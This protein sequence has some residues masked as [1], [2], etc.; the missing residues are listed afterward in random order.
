MKRNRPDIIGGAMRNRNIVIIITLLFM[1]TGVVALIKMP[2]NE[3]PV[4]TIRQGV[5]IGVF[6]GATSSEVEAQLTRV[7]ENYIFSYKEINKAKTY[8][9]S[10]EGMMYIFVQL[11]DNV[12]NS[13]QFWSKI[14]H[15]LSE[16]KMTLPA[17]VIAL[18][19]NSDFGDTSALLITLSSDNRSYKELEE[20]LKKLESECRKIPATSKIRHFGLQK[21]KIFVDIRPEMLNEYNIKAISLLGSYRLDGMVNYAGT[22]KDSSNNLA[23]H[24]P[25]NYESE[26]DL[27]DQIV[28]S[29]PSGN[30]VRLKNIASIERRYGEPDNYI[31]Q[32]GKK[33]ILLSLEM[34]TGNNIVEYGKQVD[35]ALANFEKTCPKDIQITK[36]SELPKYVDDSIG[37]FL[38]EFLVAIVSVMLVTMLLLPFRIASVAGITV[39][40]SVLVTLSFLYF[41]GVELHMVSLSSL[42]LVLGMIVDNAIVVI[43]N[44]VE[45]IDQGGSSW[46]AAIRSAKELFIP[47]VTATLAIMAAY[48]PLG[49]IL[50][51]SVGEF[52]KTIPIVVSTALIVSILVACFLVPYLN[53]TFIK[54]GLRRRASDRPTFLDK[55]Q[56]R[57][58]KALEGAFRHPKMILGSTAILLGISV[59]IFL[60]LDQQLFPEVERN[61]FVVEINLPAGSSLK[62]TGVVVDSISRLLLK[63]KR[64][65]HVTSFTGTSSPR[66]HTVYAPNMPAPHYG[67]LLVNTISDKA[68]RQVVKEYN[69][70]YCNIF[71]NAHVS[72]RILALSTTKIPIEIRISSDSI[73]D[74]RKVESE[75]N[76][77][78]KQ[79]SHIYWV[80]NDWDQMQQN[81]RVHLDHDKANRLGY[82]KTFVS[83]GLM[84]GLEGLPLTTI[85]EDDYPVEVRLSQKNEGLKGIRKLEDQSITSPLSMKST[86]LRSFATFSPE[87]TEGTIA[88]RNGIRTM[89]IQVDNDPSVTATRIFKQIK[90][91]IEKLSLP[92]GTSISYG[93]EY[94][95]QLEV[96]D[97]MIVALMLSI[98]IIFFILLF[99]FKKIK[100]T[101]LII[102]TMILAFPG[103]AIGLKLMGYNFSVTAFIGISSLCGMVVRNGII[104]VDYIIK[105]RKNKNIT[106]YEAALAAGK[107]RMRPIFLTSS[108]AAVGVI[109]MIISGSLLWGPLGTVICFGLILAMVLTLFVL[110]ILY[111]VLFK[112]TDKMK[113]K[114]NIYSTGRLKTAGLIIIL[115]AGPVWYSSGQ[116]SYSLDSCKQISLEN[117][118]QLGNSM[119]ELDISKQV[120]QAA[121]T[122]YFPNVSASGMTIS[123]NEPLISL[124]IK[125]GNLPV[126]NGDPTTI[127]HA[128]QFAYSPGMSISLLDRLSTGMLNATQPLF[129]GGRIYFGN[130]LAKVGVSASTDKLILTRNEVL[131]KTEEQYWT[132]QTLTDKLKTIDMYNQLL[133][134]LERDVKN[135]YHSGLINHNDLLRVSLKKSELEMNRIRLQNGIKLAK[136]AFCQQMGILYDSNMVLSDTVPADQDP[137][138]YLIMS[139]KV[140][141]N[142]AEY[143]LVQENVRAGQ[144][145]YKMKRGE[146]LPELAVGT[147]AFSYNM[148]D[149]WNNKMMLY[150]TLTIPLSGWWEASHTLKEESLKVKMAHNNAENNEKLLILQVEKAWSDLVEAYEQIR[151]ADNSVRLA[152]ENLKIADDNYHSGLIGVSGLLE[153]QTILQDSLNSMTD[154]RYNY[155]IRLA[156]Y[157]VVTERYK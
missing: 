48:I 88:H 18:I 57:F 62:S 22:L 95:G 71:P 127:P 12:K 150:G 99:Q 60:N 111:W 123:F 76:G 6:P 85:W 125:G 34:Q 72:Y 155:R 50:P 23:V 89:S 7:V 134:T 119:I 103:G 122:K 24:L 21:E 49:F 156:R 112:N 105:L 92:E 101:L 26:K 154:A 65:T 115:L 66:F 14:K 152:R 59:V 149:S 93:G 128:T 45:K 153:A 151:L 81:I 94:E 139:E 19:A 11:N 35:K 121:F 31:R 16:L 73:K 44:H 68:T 138:F 9:Y 117:N 15:G 4:F 124:N 13:D 55:L 140:I 3:F 102:F 97:P 5:I 108:A 84:M 70:R 58:N 98:G 54:K 137:S 82:T 39:P 25:A 142:K 110:P 90:P 109:P 141:K 64:V 67:Q 46:H 80:R 86:P 33:T 107:R 38:I 113:S 47:I 30:V 136:M 41:F 69:A 146:Y 157:L 83:T 51:G 144:L 120:R 32:D 78:L 96:F 106:V 74:I 118:S 56:S 29:D 27:A 130:Q 1:I 8:S 36:I 40:I 114:K 2:R 87:W 17:G 135:A 53:F 20:Q 91:K 143:R 61:Q 116:K 126:Y 28:Y 75:I 132:I 148:D 63:D 131:F 104:L 133:D 100:L 129:T 43:D 37:N 42:I 147:G 10:R 52:V 145:Q 79:T 77:I